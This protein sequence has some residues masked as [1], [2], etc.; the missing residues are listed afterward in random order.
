[1]GASSRSPSP[2]TMVPAHGDGVHGVAHGLGGNLVGE[3]ALA[4]SHGAGG[5][6]GG[7]FH[8]AQESR[9]RSLSIFSP[10]RAGLAFYASLRSHSDLSRRFKMRRLRAG[11]RL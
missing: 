1:M 8:D 6:D 2:I 10:K 9:S 4:L 5:S 11:L 3:L 7:D